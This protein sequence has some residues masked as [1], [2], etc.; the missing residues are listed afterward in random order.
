MNDDGRYRTYRGNILQR[1][2]V[3]RPT[4]E[5]AGPPD[6]PVWMHPIEFSQVRAVLHAVSPKAMVE[7]GSGGSSRAWLEALP[8]LELL[9]SVEHDE[10]W[11]QKVRESITDPRFR[12]ELRPP[13]ADLPEPVH[14]PRNHETGQ[15]HEAWCLKLEHEPEHM[16]HYVD[17]PEEAGV[18]FDVALVDGRA[19]IH[20]LRKAFQLLRPG[21]VVVLHDAQR[22]VYQPTLQDL[23]RPLMLEPWVQGQVCVLRT[24]DA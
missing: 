9:F 17:A 5:L 22:P 20:C 8:D 10:T 1:L 12:L 6:M 24:P 23:G 2:G 16:R 14:I 21:G 18:P 13:P 15:R 19:R 7:W 11:A 4:P 3:Q